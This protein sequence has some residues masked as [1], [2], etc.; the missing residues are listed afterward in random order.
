VTVNGIIRAV[1]LIRGR[2][3]GTWRLPGGRVELNL[4]SEQPP[5]TLR[6]LARDQAA[7]Q[8]YLA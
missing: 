8:A 1:A 2:V 5:T 4:W 7:V 3:A 6:A